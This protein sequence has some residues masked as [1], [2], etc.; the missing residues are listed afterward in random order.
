MRLYLKSEEFKCR[1]RSDKG[2][3]LWLRRLS[4][5]NPSLY[6]VTPPSDPLLNPILITIR[7]AFCPG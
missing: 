3:T 2:S 7:M 4:Y 5:S 1:C 6:V